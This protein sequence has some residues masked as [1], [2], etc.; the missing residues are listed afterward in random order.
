MF[1]KPTPFCFLCNTPD[2]TYVICEYSEQMRAECLKLLPKR[3]TPVHLI[4]LPGACAEISQGW[5]TVKNW[6]GCPSLKQAWYGCVHAHITLPSTVCETGPELALVWVDLCICLE[7]Y[8]Q[9]IALY[10]APSLSLPLPLPFPSV[11]SGPGLYTSGRPVHCVLES[12]HFNEAEIFSLGSMWW[13]HS[14]CCS[15]HSRLAFPYFFIGKNAERETMP[16]N[17]LQK[18]LPSFPMFR[19]PQ[20]LKQCDY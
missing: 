20:A 8:E 16:W 3:W 1:S 13:R 19:P 14:I 9:G 4:R 12:M 2:T 7:Q 17:A 15:I 18:F 11:N 6:P 10:L 5:G